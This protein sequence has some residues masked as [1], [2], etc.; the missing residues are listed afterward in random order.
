MS[1][2]DQ[3]LDTLTGWFR[4]LLG[5]FMAIF[6]VIEGFLRELL[7]QI[8][9]PGRLHGTIILLVAVLFIVAVVRLFGGLFR[10]LLTV[11]LILL[12]V[13]VLAPILGI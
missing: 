8:G 4:A 12:I 5:A 9:V 3:A 11:F 7:V 2:V 10:I 13:H 1:P 6:G